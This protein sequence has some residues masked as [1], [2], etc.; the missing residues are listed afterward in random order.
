MKKLLLMAMLMA[1][2]SAFAQTDEALLGCWEMRSRAG[3]RIQLLRSGEF[4]FR[5]YNTRKGDWDYLYGTW[6]YRAGKLTL[7]YADRSKQSFTVRR[8]GRRFLLT[9]AGGFVMTK[10]DPS[11]CNQ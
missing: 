5:D 4:S 10:A 11:V 2:N 3:E 1:A 9:K 8:Q 7:L 6:D